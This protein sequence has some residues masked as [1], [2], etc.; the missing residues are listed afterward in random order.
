MWMSHCL[1][2]AISAPSFGSAGGG[3]PS[4]PAS[5]PPE[6]LAVVQFWKE[7]GAALWF[8]KVPEFDGRFRERF[9][10]EYERARTGELDG[11]LSTPEG[12]LALCLLLDQYPRNSFRG[13]PR[14]YDSDAKARSVADAALRAGHDLK[15]APALALF[16]YLPFGH[17]ESLADQERSVALSQRLGRPSLDHAEGHRD[18]VARFGRF[19]H[20]NP[21]LGRAMTAEEQR[22]LDEGGYSG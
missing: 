3:A 20:R 15:I 17:S 7:A 10:L 2:L 8:A 4:V 18:I 1:R 19:P 9:A 21:I 5:T 14:M 12:A 11:W 16:I 6:A 13:T 22:F